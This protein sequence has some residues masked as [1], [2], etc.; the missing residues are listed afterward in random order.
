MWEGPGLSFLSYRIFGF[1]DCH[2]YLTNFHSLVLVE[3][4]K[5]LHVE[6]GMISQR[7]VYTCFKQIHGIRDV[8]D[9]SPIAKAVQTATEDQVKTKSEVEHITS[10]IFQLYSNFLS[11]EARQPWS[12]IMAEKINSSPWKD[13]RG[14]I[15]ISPRSKTW[16]SFRE[17]ITF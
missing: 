14:I 6:L 10:Q 2:N 11:D 4:F 15:H 5:V 8:R 3:I 9:D 1:I 16:D 7:S 12:K 13:L 17:C